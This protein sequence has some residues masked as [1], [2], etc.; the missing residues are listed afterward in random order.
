MIARGEMFFFYAFFCP[1]LSEV[2]A[3]RT[4]RGLTGPG[5]PSIGRLGPASHLQGECDL[6]VADPLFRFL[7]G[8]NRNGKRYVA[9]NGIGRQRPEKKMGHGAVR[10]LL[11]QRGEGPAL[12]AVIQDLYKTRSAFLGE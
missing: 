4:V 8:E 6:A 1:V 2:V 12:K 3:V 7:N 5:L 10:H 9:G 11:L